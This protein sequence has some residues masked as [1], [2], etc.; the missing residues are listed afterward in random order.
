MNPRPKILIIGPNSVLWGRYGAQLGLDF[1]I[2]SSI[3]LKIPL[4][5]NSSLNC[6]SL[7]FGCMNFENTYVKRS[8]NMNRY[9]DY[10][11]IFIH[12]F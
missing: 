11:R 9:L 4:Q 5:N 8:F 3:I 6:T 7:K 10:K 1:E 12:I 2:I